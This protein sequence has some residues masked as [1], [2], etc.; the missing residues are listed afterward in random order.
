MTAGTHQAPLAM[1]L[2]VQVPGAP[3]WAG[4]LGLA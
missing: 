4:S 3:T 1:F 2:G